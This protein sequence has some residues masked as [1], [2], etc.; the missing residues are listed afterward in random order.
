MYAGALRAVEDY[1]EGPYRVRRKDGTPEG[2][3]EVTQALS[4]TQSQ[5]AFHTAWLRIGA[6]AAVSAAYQELVTTAVNEAG[7]QMTAA[8]GLPPTIRDEDV[9]LGDPYPRTRSDAALG[10]VKEAMK[11]HS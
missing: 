11:R 5:I 7:P 1:L 6:P 2:R 8:W 3:R 9:P 10:K 4:S